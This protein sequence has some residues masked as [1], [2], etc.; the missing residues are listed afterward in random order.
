MKYKYHPVI[1]HLTYFILT[2]L[3]LRHQ[4]IMPNDILLINSIILTLFIIILDQMFIDGHLTPFDSFNDYI[5]EDEVRKIKKKLKKEKLK[6]KKMKSDDELIDELTSDK[7]IEKHI[8][9]ILDEEDNKNNT[10]DNYRNRVVSQQNERNTEKFEDFIGNLDNIETFNPSGSFNNGSF[11]NDSFN[12][13]SFN[14]G[15]YNEVESFN[16]LGYNE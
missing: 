2:Y 12:N 11:N 4:K 5:D 16:V 9:R 10:T 8:N 7:D 3:F 6:K 15:S 1:K 14:N 13:D